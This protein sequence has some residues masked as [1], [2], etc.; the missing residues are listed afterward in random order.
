MGYRRRRKTTAKKWSRKV[1]GL[2]VLAALSLAG[3][4][5]WAPEGDL[6]P[7]RVTRVVDGDTIDVIL[8]GGREERVRLI[9][10]NAPES[11]GKVEPYGKEASAYAEKRLQ[12][13]NVY[14]EMDVGER[15]KYGRL[16]A[17]VWLEPPQAASEEEI[18]A[19]M[20]NA[21]LLLHGYAQVMTVPP[22]VKYSSLFVELERE[23]RNEGRGLWGLKERL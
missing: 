22:N 6:Q 20:F 11:R 17:Y 8:A 9:G 3:Y 12:G 15:D 19:K 14:L 10:V 13:R 1:L 16:L 5:T 18:R 21:E 2:V 4:L 23:A 7:A